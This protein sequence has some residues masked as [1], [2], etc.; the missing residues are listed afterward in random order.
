MYVT[1]VR[2]D[3]TLY[4]GPVLDRLPV[5]TLVNVSMSQTGVL[6]V[7]E[8][9]DPVALEQQARG[10]E[11]RILET[12][13]DWLATEDTEELRLFGA[14]YL[15][16]LRKLTAKPP[17]RAAYQIGTVDAK[18]IR[19]YVEVAWEDVKQI[20]QPSYKTSG[21]TTGRMSVSQPNIQNV[22]KSLA[23]GIDKM[24]ERGALNEQA[25]G[26]AD[27]YSEIDRGD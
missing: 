4:L 1:E 20:R 21:V 19:A 8:C 5:G 9:D 25:E 12:L 13:S 15:R 16:W 24:M 14:H 2:H 3:G 23:D 27:Y 10:R 11:D 26:I 18:R 6:L 7:S 22:P 17:T